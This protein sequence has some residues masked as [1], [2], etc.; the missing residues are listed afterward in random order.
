MKPKV[1]AIVPARG[2]SKS[3]PYK[4][5]A[6]LD[7][8]PLMA[9]AIE[10][11]KRSHLVDRIVVTTDDEKIAVVAKK[12]GAEIP[13][14]RPK[15]L[16]TDTARIFDSFKHAIDTLKEKENYRP[17]YV[18][19][20]QP[21]S[22]LVQTKQIDAALT[23]AFEKKAESVVTVE[24][25]PHCSHP[26]NI[27]HIVKGKTHFWM[28]KEHYDVSNRQQRPKFFAFGNL[29]VSRIDLIE[30]NGLLEGHDNYQVVIDHLTSL[31]VDSREDLQIIECLLREK[32]VM[33]E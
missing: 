16:A 14:M 29:Y 1:L 27:R 10:A 11:L 33:P 7:G 17:D 5:I 4:N 28:E 24:L 8:K 25:L 15:E 32:V 6:L 12:Y 9:Y 30:K 2:G 3:I 26:H 31:D 21:T 22:P 13:F 19:T 20:V 23:L 18:I